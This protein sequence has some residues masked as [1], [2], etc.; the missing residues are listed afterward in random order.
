MKLKDRWYRHV[1][2]TEK[3]Y[4]QTIIAKAIRKYGECNFK[5]ETIDVGDSIEELNKKEVFWIKH[6]NSRDK[7]IGYNIAIGGKNSK[8]TEQ[9][10]AK[11][12]KHKIKNKMISGVWYYPKD[13]RWCYDLTVNGK[14]YLGKKYATKIDAQIAKDIKILELLPI[15]LAKN[16]LCLP[17]NLQKYL[18]KELLPKKLLKSAY[19]KSKY[20][21]VNYDH[22]W[23]NWSVRL[24]KDNITMFRGPKHD[25]ETEAAEF[26]DY[27]IIKNS[28]LDIGFELNFPEN[29]EKYKSF[30]Y[31]PPKS[32]LEKRRITPY[33]FIGFNKARQTYSVDVRINLKGFYKHC[34]TLEE[35]KSFRDKVLLEHN[36]PIPD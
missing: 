23:E 26:A 3:E 29:I 12:I 34:K 9:T 32:S 21:Y 7:N 31:I 14:T 22:K 17:E 13:G 36:I 19:K 25:T 16:R 11:M 20:K 5:V 6:Y 10:I 15:D 1:H 28:L 4:K 24:I 18:N 35:A 2:N 27:L 8:P 30:N 33:K